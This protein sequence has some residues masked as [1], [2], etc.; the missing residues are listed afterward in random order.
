MGEFWAGSNLDFK[1]FPGVSMHGTEKSLICVPFNPLPSEAGGKLE[2]IAAV[3]RRGDD[4]LDL[5]FIGGRD[6]K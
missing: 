4:G 1:M 2:S 5:G 3:Q 6:E